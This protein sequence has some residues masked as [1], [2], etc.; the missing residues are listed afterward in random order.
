MLRRAPR[1][2]QIRA[3]LQLTA[4]CCRWS[5]AGG[6]GSEVRRLCS[7]VD[8]P[9]LLRTA[10]FHR[11]EGHVWNCLHSIAADIPCEIRDALLRDTNTIVATNLHILLEA[12]DVCLAF[13][14]Q[15][16]PVLTLKGLTVGALAYPNPMLKM[17][18]DIDILIAGRDLDKAAA[19][20]SKRGYC[21]TIPATPADLKRWHLTRKESVWRRSSDNLHIEIHTR[22]ADNPMLIPGVGLNS[23]QQQV[24]ILAGIS[25][26]T[27][28][29][30]ELIAYLC[31]HGASS[32]WFRLKW[33]TDLAAILHRLGPD[34]LEHVYERSL[35][36]GAG[37][38]SAL[39]FLHA[40]DLFGTLSAT[41]LRARLE[42][43]GVS[44]WL[45]R[46]A[47]RQVA[48][49]AEQLEPT[50]RLFGTVR[51]HLTQFFLLR[52]VRFK[53]DEL[54]RQARDSLT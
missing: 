31:V 18:W 44:R 14:K 1:D 46:S 10:R 9:L 39:A 6:D 7:E 45:A 27:L 43:D 5:F 22:L 33:I 19:E 51:I 3:E 53:I 38:A 12:R 29:G 13:T 35:E 28:A 20:L 16:V 36:L 4:E 24:E 32:L 49:S 17:G 15:Q 23:P 48:H 30:D 42:K 40:D 50:E 26:P 11:V 41:R 37:R 25:L 47:F 34:R 54:L 8:W 21:P 2:R 52:S